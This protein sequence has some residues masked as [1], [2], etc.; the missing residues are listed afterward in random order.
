[1]FDPGLNSLLVMKIGLAPVVIALVSLVERRFG[2]GIAGSLLGLPVTSGPLLFCLTLQHGTTFS[3]HAA[4]GTLLGL[5]ALATFAITYAQWSQSRGWLLS[6]AIAIGSYFFVSAVLLKLPIRAGWTLAAV[7]LFLSVV[8]LVFPRTTAGAGEQRKS[9]PREIWLR[10]GV[11]GSIVFLL[12]TA[13]RLFGPEVSGLLATFPVYS[14][15]LAVCN[16]IK[17]SASAIGILKGVVVGT[18]GTAAFCGVLMLGLTVV[19]IAFCFLL[20][21]TSAVAVQALL[22]PK[23][24]RSTA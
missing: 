3:A 11:A 17:S 14:G 13:A 9:S 22:Y 1:M 12:A 8:L 4:R 21:A 20:A 6:I 24:R 19:P 10:M 7:C 18:L 5:V 16:H 2:R 15:V 23:L